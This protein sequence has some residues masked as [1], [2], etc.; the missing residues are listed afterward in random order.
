MKTILFTLFGLMVAGN[1]WGAYASYN[2]IE[3]MLNRGSEAMRKAQ[4]GTQITTKKLHV[5]KAVYDFTVVG[6]GIGDVLLKDADGKDAVIPKDAIITKVIVNS[7]RDLSSTGSATVALKLQTAADLK[8]AVTYASYSSATPI[9]AGVPVDT[10]ATMFKLT[11]QRQVKA[12]IATAS[13]TAGKFNAYV[14]YYLG[15]AASTGY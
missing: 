9:I 5:M 4:L 2:D 14:E 6:G 8:A 13:L 3:F 7:L 1:S 11:A 15:D 12:T 10:A